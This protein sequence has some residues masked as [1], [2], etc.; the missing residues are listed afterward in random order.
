MV[1]LP[2]RQEL[3]KDADASTQVYSEKY[4]GFWVAFFLPTCLFIFAPV[5]LVLCRKNYVLTPPTGSI[6]A[7]FFKLWSYASKGKWI[8]N[9]VH[10]YK[11]MSAPDFWER[12]KPS[13]LP[14]GQRPS[15]MTFDDAWVEEVRRGG[16]LVPC[17]CTCHSTGVRVFLS[18]TLF[19]DLWSHFC[20]R[21]WFRQHWYTLMETRSPL[22]PNDW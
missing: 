5:L 6:I 1:S 8:I 3:E 17:S 7:K 10:T 16:R 21:F 11:N 18:E 9:P 2:G 22:W 15:W 14:A 13:H 20:L 12:V 4:V 19:C